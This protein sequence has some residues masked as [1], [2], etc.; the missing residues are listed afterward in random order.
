MQETA[1]HFQFEA[2]FVVSLRCIPM[3]VRFKLDAV[4]LKVKL[5]HWAKF[6]QLDRQMLAETPCETVEEIEAYKLL[7]SNLVRIRTGE[8]LQI[9]PAEYEPGWKQ[10]NVPEQ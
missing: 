10:E 3:H 2:D 1:R 9:L 7:L 6:E 5:S 4:G 8:S